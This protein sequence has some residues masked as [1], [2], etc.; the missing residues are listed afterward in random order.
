MV[1]KKSSTFVLIP[2]LFY[3]LFSSPPEAS[4]KKKGFI[5]A[6]AAVILDA[7]K[8]IIYARNPYLKLPPAS[9]TKVMTA[10]IVIER[11]KLDK[12]VVISAH[13]ASVEPSKAY[14][15]AG[16]TYSTAE[17]LK[18]LLL[19]SAND[20]AVALAEDVAGSEPQFVRL[21]NSRA[22]ALGARN[23]NFVNSSGL[24]EKGKNQYSSAY[25]LALIMREAMRHPEFVDIMKKKEDVI[26]GAN[27]ARHYLRNHNK[28]L[29]QYPG[30]VIGK[31]G[32]TLAA[33]HCFVGASLKE[34]RRVV[35]AI[36]HSKDLWGDGTKLLRYAGVVKK[37]SGKSAKQ[38]N[39]RKR[40]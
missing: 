36:L 27:G 33:R 20:A 13:S 14:L 1:L 5:S 22:R 28:F 8:S 12:P 24:T 34:N 3:L 4:A 32:F 16:V 6:K 29:W 10:L 35:F 39:K 21:M 19:N 23:T 26:T 2:L 40:R 31:T 17:L 30:K 25:D 18:A 38:G 7:K 37:Y 9:T 11:S 15:R